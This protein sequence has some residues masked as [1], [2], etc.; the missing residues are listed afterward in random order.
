MRVNV[1]DSLIEYY[2]HA[3]R[4]RHNRVTQNTTMKTV[5]A[6][7]MTLSPKVRP[8]ILDR[9]FQPLVCFPPVFTT[10]HE[11]PDYFQKVLLCQFIE[12]T[13]RILSVRLRKLK[14]FRLHAEHVGCRS[15]R[16]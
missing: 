2:K 14:M 11:L 5:Y 15:V 1:A 7:L 16:G 9:R 6:R 10:S 8:Q 12:T 3:V 13:P 4:Q